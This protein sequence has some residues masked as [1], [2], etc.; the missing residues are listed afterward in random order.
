MHII[1]RFSNIQQLKTMHPSSALL[2][3]SIRRIFASILHKPALK[4]IMIANLMRKLR[5]RSQNV[6][7]H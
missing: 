1:V 4:K 5:E 6:E 3:S 2:K 7:T